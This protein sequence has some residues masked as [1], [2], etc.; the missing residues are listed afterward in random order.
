MR[1]LET[2][3]ACDKK[4]FKRTQTLVQ[5]LLVLVL[6]LVLV[7]ADPGKLLLAGD[8]ELALDAPPQTRSHH[9]QALKGAPQSVLVRRL[10]VT[11]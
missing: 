11:V 5:E 4:D 10:L 9:E 2:L 6:V 3:L 1:D 8:I 7:P